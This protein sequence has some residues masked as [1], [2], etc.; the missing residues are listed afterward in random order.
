MAKKQFWGRKYCSNC[1]R[2]SDHFAKQSYWLGITS[3]PVGMPKLYCG[4][5]GDETGF[6]SEEDLDKLQ[7]EIDEF[8]K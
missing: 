3:I 6:F 7:K 5:C 8:R 2:K 4:T 1:K